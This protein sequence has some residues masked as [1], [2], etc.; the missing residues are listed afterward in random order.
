MKILKIIQEEIVPLSS[1]QNIILLVI[2]A[3]LFQF[4]LFY[5]PVLAATAVATANADNSELIIT[6]QLTKSLLPA[7]G[8][9]NAVPNKAEDNI[10]KD[11]PSDIVDI[12]NDATPKTAPEPKIIRVSTHVITAYNSEVAQTDS[13]PCTTA[14][15]FNLCKNNQED[16]VAANFLKFGTKIKIPE[17]F[18]DKVFVVRDRM[19]KRHSNRLDVWMKNHQDAINFGVKTAQIQVLE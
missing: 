6:D 2:I 19:N 18:G 14:N 17:L 3:C 9:T 12:K 5:T 16:T 10:I 15:G 13:D 1:R 4:V 8:L 11:T 7:E